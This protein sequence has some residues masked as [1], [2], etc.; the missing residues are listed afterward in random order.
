MPPEGDFPVA[1]PDIVS[2]ALSN[3]ARLGLG[4]EMLAHFAERMGRCMYF[5][6]EQRVWRSV[7]DEYKKRL[8]AAKPSEAP[9]D[10][11]EFAA[12]CYA[13]HGWHGFDAAHSLSDES[14]RAAETLARIKQLYAGLP[15]AEYLVAEAERL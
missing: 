10:V 15:A 7:V 1:P 5:D 14:I 6:F 2:V 8:E 3:W 12:R 4:G 11:K 13:G 9:P